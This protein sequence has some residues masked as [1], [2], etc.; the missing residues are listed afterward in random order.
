MEVILFGFGRI[1]QIHYKNLL[2]NKKFKLTHIIDIVDIREKISKDITFINSND[3][4]KL[5]NLLN[6]KNI[7]AVIIATPT[8]THYKYILLAL[9]NK[10]HVFVEKPITDNIREINDCYNLAKLN[11]LILFVAYNRRYDPAI[12]DIKSRINS[13]GKINYALTISRDYPYPEA[14]FLKICSGIFHDCATHDIDYLNWILNDKPIS[15]NVSVN[16]NEKVED[17]NYDYVL[18][19]LNYPQGTIASLNLSRVSQCYD[20]RCEFFG[21]N[22]EIINNYY[23]KNSKYS[24]PE[25]YYISYQNELV[26]FYNSIENNTEPGVSREDCITNYIIAEACQESINKNQ[27]IT[28]KY[29]EG[30]RNYNIVNNAVKDNYF[31]SRKNQ[32]LEFVQKMSEKF[33]IFNKM[34]IWDILQNL[35]N[36]VDVSDPDSSHPNLYHAIQTAEMI[37]KDGHPKW[38]QIVG[39][40]HDIGKIMYLRGNNEEGTGKIK[41]WAMV[42]DTFIVGCKL[43]NKI[44]FPEFNCQNPDMKN[45][46]Y[47]TELG[48][49]T[50]GCGLDNLKC[51]WGHDE[52]LYQILSSERNPHYLP[53]EALYIIRFHSLY[54]YHDK[55]EYMRF[56]NDKDKKYFKYLKLFNKY[57]LYS[58]S[59]Q[60]YD[61]QQLKPYYLDLIS[62]YFKHSYLFI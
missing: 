49:Y 42:G 14:R 25:R 6:N 40:I 1:G 15:V 10:K 54:V 58:K 47:N 26:E 4:D 11:N 48:I 41:Q 55:Q 3:K 51:S 30:F 18:I 45:P 9:N 34:E 57:D 13:I 37:R 50:E 39:L 59:D 12:K 24:F 29:G 21:E 7:K 16:N 46:S 28:I 27:K 8:K 53:P 2:I 61:I 17:Y 60:I 22:G 44:I 19:N 38:L 31:L 20:Q 5:N 56:Q 33:A 43:S 52:Y 36:L 32:T 35:N 23:D 62:Q